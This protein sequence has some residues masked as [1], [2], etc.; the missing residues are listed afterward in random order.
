MKKRIHISL[1]IFFVLIGIGIIGC[2]GGTRANLPRV[3]N[4]T[5]SELKDNWENYTT[6]YRPRIAF[7][8]KLKN[9]RKIILDDKWIEVST[10]EM[11]AKSPIYDLTWIRKILGQNDEIYG[12]LVHRTADRANVKIIDENTVQLYYHYVRTSGR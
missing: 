7:I 5:E 4:P 6:Y 1:S 2:T 8:Y 3:Q 11:M 9:N 10:S 12:Y